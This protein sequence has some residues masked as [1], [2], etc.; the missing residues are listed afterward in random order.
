MKVLI[1]SDTYYPHVNGASYFTQR[2]ADALAERGHE[3]GVIAPSLT[4]HNDTLLRGKVHIF[5]VHSFP[6]LIVPKFRFVFPW[7]ISRRISRV[8][9]EFNPDIVHIQMHF[10]V[11]RTVLNEAR[12]RGIPVV[13]TN[14][15]MPDNLTHYLH[16]PESGHAI[17]QFR[18]VV[19]RVACPW[20]S[21]SDLRPDAD[22]RRSHAA[23]DHEKDAR[24]LQR[25]RSC[26]FQS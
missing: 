4:V 12:K 16:L 26:A 3:V 20:Q 22:E 10:P 17:D 21:D 15:F 7:A 23:A 6:I 18:H 19:G 2:L 9:D 5:G 11:S 24:D 8:M 14:H 1:A 25:Y 13:A